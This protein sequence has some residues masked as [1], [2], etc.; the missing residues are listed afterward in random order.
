MALKLI[1]VGLRRSGTTIFWR[2]FRQDRRLLCYDEPFNPNLWVL[3]ERSGLKAPEEFRALLENDPRAFWEAFTPIHFTQE[4]KEGLSD[5]QRA[6]LRFVG[7]SGQRVVVD[8]TRCAFKIRALAEE[9]P[10]AVLVHLYRPPESL[11]SS[12]LLPSSEGNRGRIKRWAA[13]RGFWTRRERYNGWS[14]ESIIGRSATSLF[15]CSPAV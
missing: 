6:W 12:H 7:E 15:A 4:L 1:I 5:R 9:A 8:T 2:T 10:G 13:R 3:P 14:F 11:A